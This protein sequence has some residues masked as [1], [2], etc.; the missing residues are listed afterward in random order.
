MEYRIPSDVH[1]IRKRFKKGEFIF[2][3]RETAVYFYLLVSGSANVVYPDREGEILQ[4]AHFTA[5]DF[6][7][8]IE[9]LT[10]NHEPLPVVASETCETLIL[11][12]ADAMRWLKTDFTF[13]HYVLKRLAQKL[14]DCTYHRAER[15]FLP[16]RQRLLLVFSRYKAEGK[17]DTLTKSILCEE[18]GV[19]IR[20]LNR[21]IAQCSDVMIYEHKH[22]HAVKHS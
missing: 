11:S 19:P 10:D 4:I 8:E 17:L 15:H 20:S 21:V 2:S 5:P 12:H 16:I 9:L 13:C 1:Y 3:G 18:I 6:F 22:F 14:Y 7:G